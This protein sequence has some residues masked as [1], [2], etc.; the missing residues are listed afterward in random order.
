MNPVRFG[1]CPATVSA[2]TAGM[3]QIPTPGKTSTALCERHRLGKMRSIGN[4]AYRRAAAV[5]IFYGP[6]RLIA[7]L[8]LA[9]L[10]LAGPL[11]AGEEM[12]IVSLSPAVTELVCQL[13]RGRFLVG[14]SEVCNYPEAVKK[15]PAVGRY[16]DPFLERV[17]ALHPTIVL[18]NDLR[19][20]RAAE[21]LRKLN[22]RLVVKQC[23]TV[24]EYR[25]WVVLLGEVLECRDRAEAELERFDGEIAEL[26]KLPPLRVRLLWVISESPLLTGGRTS[27]LSEVSQLA[28]MKNSGDVSA[29][30]YF[31]ISR[32]FLLKNPPEVIVWANSGAVP[33]VTTPFWGE[34]EA[35]RRGR[36]LKYLHEDTV[37][38]PGPRMPEGIRKLRREAELLVS[39]GAK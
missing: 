1:G 24:D 11:S 22:I 34:L 19:S 36:V 8:V 12:R 3:S 5:K 20:P 2:E 7:I 16:A 13:G 9:A 14:R 10:S 39:G 26:R 37:M 15:L 33:G 25:E 29:V 31:R 4:V 17:V 30:A 28:G 27:L 38:R 23:R 32:D 18:T 21:V 6:N 35:I